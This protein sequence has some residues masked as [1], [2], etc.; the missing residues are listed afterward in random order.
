MTYLDVLSSFVGNFDSRAWGT[1]AV[2]MQ[3]CIEKDA[4]TSL[5]FEKPLV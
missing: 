5:S 4:I 2:R 3:S 1:R